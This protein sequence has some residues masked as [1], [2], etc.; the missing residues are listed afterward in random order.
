MSPRTLSTLFLGGSG[1]LWPAL[2]ANVSEGPAPGSQ[3]LHPLAEVIA[4]SLQCSAQLLQPLDFHL[5][6][7]QLFVPEGFLGEK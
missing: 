7:F 5:Q 4:L 1:G 2:R 3:V 6:A